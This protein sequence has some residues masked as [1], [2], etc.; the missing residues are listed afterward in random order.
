[1]LSV[2]A[3]LLAGW[4]ILIASLFWDPLSLSITRPGNLA[5]P[6]HARGGVMVQGHMVTSHAYYLGN[7]I[8]WTIIVPIL[9]LYLM[10]FGHEA[11]RRVCPLSFASQL[12]LYLGL[13]RR[14]IVVQHRTGKLER[15]PILLKQSSWLRKYSWYVQAGLLFSGLNARL[16]FINSDRTALA[17]SLL[18]VILSAM[19]VGYL[20]GG[21]TWCNFICPANIVQR[22]YTEPR[23][24]LESRPH[25]QQRGIPQ[26][27]CR[28]TT[29]SGDKSTCVGCAPSCG[30]VDLER[31]YWETLAEPPRRNVY[32]MFF[33]LI[34]AFYGYYYL[35][36]GNW[37]YYFSGIWTH[38]DN[39]IGAVLKPGL[40]IDHHLLPV[41]KLLAVPLVLGSGVAAALLLGKFAER[42][43]R[44]FISVRGRVSETEIIHH[45]LCVSAYISINTFYMF[46][47]RPNLMMLPATDVLLADIVIAAGSTIW[48]W[49]AIRRT[50]AKYRRESLASSLIEQLRKMKLNFAEYFDGRSLDDL[51]PDEVYL[52][53]KLLP[54][55][56]HDH[57]IK[58]YKNILDDAVTSGKTNSAQ[59]LDMLGELRA[60]MGVSDEEHSE[61]LEQ[62]ARPTAISSDMK[63]AIADEKALSIIS[64]TQMLGSAVA[65]HIEDGKDMGYVLNSPEIAATVSVLRAS[66]QI[67]ETEHAAVLGSFVARD[68]V[69]VRRANTLLK[70]IEDMLVARL[71]VLT[72]GIGNSLWRAL[73]ALLI[74]AIDRHC[75]VLY[76]KLFSILRTFGP[77]PEGRWYAASFR[78]LARESVDAA[79]ATSLPPGW[80]PTWEDALGAEILTILSGAASVIDQIDEAPE[81]AQLFNYGD[82]IRAGRDTARNVRTLMLHQDK[83]V[84]TH[85]TIAL[86]YSHPD[87]AQE[88]ASEAIHREDV[89]GLL[90]AVRSS[91]P[92]KVAE[93][94]HANLAAFFEEGFTEGLI[95]VE[96]IADLLADIRHALETDDGGPLHAGLAAFV[97]QREDSTPSFLKDFRQALEVPSST[98]AQAPPIVVYQEAVPALAAAAIAPLQPA[99]H[100]FAPATIWTRGRIRVRCI[101][102]TEEAPE[103]KTYTL[104]AVQPQLFQFQPGQFV[105]L[106][107]PA[108]GG[109][110]SRSYTISSSPS[111]PSNLSVTVKRVPMGLVSNWLY[112]NMAEGFEFDLSGPYGNFSCTD[113]QAKKVL[114]I[115]AGSGVTPMMSMLRYLS[116]TVSGVDIAFIN[117]VRTPADVIFERELLHISALLG[118]ALKLGV[119][120]SKVLAGQHWNGLRGRIS[121]LQLMAIAPDFIE[122][123]TFVCGPI[124][125]TA[126][127]RSMLERL[128]YPMHRF[129]QESFGGGKPPVRAKSHMTSAKLTQVV[130]Q[131]SGLTLEGIVGE[132]V[133]TIGHRHGVAMSSVCRVGVCGACRIKKIDGQVTMDGQHALSPDELDDGHILACVAQV[134]GRLVVDA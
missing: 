118:P 127:V 105:T 124:G 29:P 32:Y 82:V 15:V 97:Q 102:V 100:T 42:T 47:G 71:F 75:L 51:R 117:N 85:A 126:L 65:P 63:R 4:F 68:G 69:L 114:M 14:R 33:G 87:V 3:L 6:F 23:G 67:T 17:I 7:R 20:W 109:M 76:L 43:Y 80:G 52:L 9:P 44:K 83:T 31:S 21:K 111:R 84:R 19:V 34:V 101:K 108:G 49:Q 55:I 113:Y 133:L 119:V 106:E 59:F 95:N 93:A 131:R 132:T 116:D 5:S 73:E 50:P 36:A 78:E 10:V 12:P 30:D 77:S 98:E 1:M 112:N 60:Q 86:R 8:F 128:G 28:K 13:Q 27:M 92:S 74:D 122:R 123:E 22:I 104:A 72:A 134:G 46:G 99:A 96:L 120:P 103:V 115:S 121:D 58:A 26:S 79:L 37:N 130:F 81:G 62:L 11:W 24:I 70:V 129:H 61:V 35:Y 16:L 56:S 94:L 25:L 40:F 39:Q 88:C 41:P 54:E 64:Y 18:G 91:L 38:E 57:K 89:A 90:D 53:G 125:Y 66:F 45:S 107:L 110:V 48:L 2:R